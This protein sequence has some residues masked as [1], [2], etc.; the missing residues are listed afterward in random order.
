[1]PGLSL[2]VCMCV[3]VSC[4]ASFLCAFFS[5]Y[6]FLLVVKHSTET[7]QGSE[8]KK[9]KHYY[10]FSPINEI[11]LSVFPSPPSSLLHGKLLSRSAICRLVT[12]KVLGTKSIF[13]LLQI[14]QSLR[15]KHNCIIKHM[16]NLNLTENL[17]SLSLSLFLTLYTNFIYANKVVEFIMKQKTKTERKL[18]YLCKK[19]RNRR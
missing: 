16:T 4:S 1:M 14:P 5:A 18:R 13:A 7:Q 8:S 2:R 6:S 15:I 10:L 9:E 12:H 3:S 19:K 17:L 11:T